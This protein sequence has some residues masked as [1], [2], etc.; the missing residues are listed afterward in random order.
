[1]AFLDFED[2]EAVLRPFQ[3][4]SASREFVALSQ[5]TVAEFWSLPIIASWSSQ[6]A[7]K[8]AACLVARRKALSHLAHASLRVLLC[9]ERRA[10]GKN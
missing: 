6:R 8:F 7:T 2:S 3:R 5:S 9:A 4:S 10:H 1:M